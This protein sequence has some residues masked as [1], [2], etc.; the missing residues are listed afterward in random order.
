LAAVEELEH[1]AFDGAWWDR[2]PCWLRVVMDDLQ[3]VV[4]GILEDHEDALVFQDDLDEL[5]YIRVTQL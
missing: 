2:M 4:L 5:D 3:E 1:D